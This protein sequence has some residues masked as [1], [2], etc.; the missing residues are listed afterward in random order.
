MATSKSL[1]KATE[2]TVAPSDD[3]YVQEESNVNVPVTPAEPIV[4]AGAPAEEA[5]VPKADDEPVVALPD[6][7][8]K[9]LEHNKLVADSRAF[10]RA[11]GVADHLYSDDTAISN[12]ERW[13]KWNKKLVPGAEFKMELDEQKSHYD[14]HEGVVTRGEYSTSPNDVLPY[15]KD[16]KEADTPTPAVL[17]NEDEV[18]GK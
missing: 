14:K 12:Y 6:N 1:P 13:K 8:K 5:G 18:T 15:Y 7:S 16:P 10:L 11:Q 4:P 17:K 3:F 2:P 9:A